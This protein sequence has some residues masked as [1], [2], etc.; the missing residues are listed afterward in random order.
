MDL[1]VT[2][3]E[4]SHLPRT[5]QQDTF[6]SSNNS[7]TLW[8]TIQQEKVIQSAFPVA[9]YLGL[10]DIH[11]CSG[12]F[13]MAPSPL[14]KQTASCNSPHDW[15][16]SLTMDLAVCVICGGDNGISGYGRVQSRV[17][18]IYYLWY[19]SIFIIMHGSRFSQ[20]Q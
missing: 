16:V 2:V 13:K 7:Y 9:F 8:L 4:K 11:K 19:F 18:R 14:N 17:R 1:Y 10:S 3:F 5:Q 20:V 12:G 6:C 15:L